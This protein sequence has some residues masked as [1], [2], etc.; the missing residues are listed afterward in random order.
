ALGRDLFHINS[1]FSETDTSVRSIQKV[2][3]IR[4]LVL[5]VLKLH[6]P[7]LVAFTTSLEAL[8]C[9]DAVNVTLDEVDSK[10]ETVKIVVA[11][12]GLDF[13]AISEKLKDLHASIHSIDQVVAGKRIVESIETPQD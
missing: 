7:D 1:S 3:T 12:Q 11:G 8:E 2:G 10:T 9:I 4:R 5:D 13:E 6:E